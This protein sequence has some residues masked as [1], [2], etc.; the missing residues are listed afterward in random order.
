MAT[1]QFQ[2]IDF[3]D[4][5]RKEVLVLIELCSPMERQE[6]LSRL[7]ETILV[8]EA[9]LVDDKGSLLDSPGYAREFLEMLDLVL[10]AAVGHDTLMQQRLQDYIDFTEYDM[11]RRLRI[12]L[13]ANS[14]IRRAP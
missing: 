12:D 1:Q 2:L 11:R 7:M 14:V 9:L 13:P 4:V 5:V 3:V 10:E 8:Q 6:L